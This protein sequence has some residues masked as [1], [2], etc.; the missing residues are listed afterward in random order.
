MTMSSLCDMSALKGLLLGSYLKK[1]QKT[2]NALHSYEGGGERERNSLLMEKKE[3]Y[4]K[5]FRYSMQH[6]SLLSLP[7]NLF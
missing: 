6:N 3:V 5:H 7:F 1:E 2:F 4:T